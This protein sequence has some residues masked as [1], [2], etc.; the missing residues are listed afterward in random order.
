MKASSVF[1]GS[2]ET[3]F[4]ASSSSPWSKKRASKAFFDPFLGKKRRFL[5]HLALGEGRNARRRLHFVFREAR[6]GV[7]CLILL[8]VKVETRVSSPILSSGKPETAFLGSVSFSVMEGTRREAF[9]TR[10]RSGNLSVAALAG[11]FAPNATQWAMVGGATLLRLMR[12]CLSANSA[13]RVTF[14]ANAPPT[15]QMEVSAVSSRPASRLS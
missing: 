6:N 10:E 15:F 9:K 3:A 7:S 2:Q 14:D 12:E 13:L 1:G 5:L 4:L 8:S 11:A